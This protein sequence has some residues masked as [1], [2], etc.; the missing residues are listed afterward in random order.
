MVTFFKGPQLDYTAT[1]LSRQTSST[2]SANQ[3]E[4]LTEW[5]RGAPQREFAKVFIGTF[6]NSDHA[7]GIYSKAPA[8]P[9]R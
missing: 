2:D 8:H 1:C 6:K 3:E 4:T 7:T 9:G 5:V